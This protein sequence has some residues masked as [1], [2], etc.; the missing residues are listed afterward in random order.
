MIKMK[1][2]NAAVTLV[3]LAS[4]A[5]L[6]PPAESSEKQ[7]NREITK[8]EIIEIGV[9]ETD[10]SK[11]ICA[12][13]NLSVEEVTEFFRQAKITRLTRIHDSYNWLPCYVRGTYTKGG[14]VFEWDINAGGFATVKSSETTTYLACDK[15]QHLFQDKR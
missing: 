3:L 11:E 1:V 5:L 15:C 12:G 2:I 7:K 13:F 6:P 4:T 9:N 10:K 8:I 14:K